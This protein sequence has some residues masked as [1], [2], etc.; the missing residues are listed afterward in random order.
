MSKP[1]TVTGVKLATMWLSLKSNKKYPLTDRLCKSKGKKSDWME[2]YWPPRKIII[3][4]VR[5]IK[6]HD[7]ISGTNLDIQPN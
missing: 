5:D 3:L 6:E 2:G 4:E 7:G 1:I